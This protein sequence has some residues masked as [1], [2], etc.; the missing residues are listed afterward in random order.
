MEGKI[1]DAKGK[2][3][4]LKGDV[5]NLEVELDRLA[6]R[7]EKNDANVRVLRPGLV[8][9][10]ISA[11]VTACILSV[12]TSYVARFPRLAIATQRRGESRRSINKYT[13]N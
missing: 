2:I 11:A 1:A 7:V 8:S 13:Y 6:T 12:I 3:E 9:A 5:G 10:A 4:D